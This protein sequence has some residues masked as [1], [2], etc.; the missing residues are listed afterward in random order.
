M[1]IPQNI[2]FKMEQEMRNNV[3]SL[4]GRKLILSFE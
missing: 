4:T 2:I 3:N 1:Q